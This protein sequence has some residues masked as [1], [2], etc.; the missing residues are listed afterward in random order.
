MTVDEVA[1]C[2]FKPRWADIHEYEAAL[3]AL[4]RMSN[5]DQDAVRRIGE[6]KYNA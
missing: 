5:A 3:S 1:K 4:R 6:D 2:L